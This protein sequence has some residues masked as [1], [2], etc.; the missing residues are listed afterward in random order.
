MSD[1]PGRAG[2]EGE[3]D[4]LGR[5]DAARDL[6]RDGD[7]GRDGPDRVQVRRR[8]G[9]RALEVDQLDEPGALG[10]EPLGD[11]VRPVGR[12]ADARPLRPGQNT[13]RERPASTSID[14]MTCTV[15]VRPRPSAGGDGS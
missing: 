10:D 4:R 9:P 7:P 15:P 3:P 1:D 5:I 8:P 13:T 14:G 6:E 12:G 11:A 2:R